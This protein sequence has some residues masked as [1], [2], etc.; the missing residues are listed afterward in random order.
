[1]KIYKMQQRSALKLNQVKQNIKK[2]ENGEKIQKKTTRSKLIEENKEN[3]RMAF[4]KISPIGENDNMLE[5][6]F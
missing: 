4:Q 1:M 3:L 6:N 5:C 2:I